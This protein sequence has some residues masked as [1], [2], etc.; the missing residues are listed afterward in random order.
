MFHS[1]IFVSSPHSWF[2][3]YRVSLFFLCQ[4]SY[5][6][7]T[8][9]M[10]CHLSLT[11]RMYV[12]ILPILLDTYHR[13]SGVEFL[14]YNTLQSIS[15]LLLYVLCHHTHCPQKMA[16]TKMV[17]FIT[18]QIYVHHFSDTIQTLY[19]LSSLLKCLLTSQL[20]FCGLSELI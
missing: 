13:I 19:S 18:D 20:T 5:E 10:Q 17:A 16:T 8:T 12:N 11:C 1:R 14:I 4:T 3:S 9:W 2:Q 6:H 7:S 15:T